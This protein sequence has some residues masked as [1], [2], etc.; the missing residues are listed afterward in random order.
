MPIRKSSAQPG[1]H[2]TLAFWQ[3]VETPLGTRH[4]VGWDVDN[5][6]GHVSAAIVTLDGQTS[7]RD[8]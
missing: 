4:C 8:D 1:G 3:V 2:R 5:G 7:A 6:K